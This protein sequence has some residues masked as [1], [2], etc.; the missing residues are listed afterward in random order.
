MKR[1]RFRTLHGRLT[2][3][4]VLVAAITICAL[5]VAFNLL[6]SQRSGADIDTRLRT[7]AAAAATTVGV[8]HGRLE[9]RESP[10]AAPLDRRVWIYAGRRAVERP[11][12]DATLQ[13]AADSMAGTAGRFKDVP[14]DGDVRLYSS[15]ITDAGRQ[16]GTVVAAQSLTA[17]ER[18]IQ[19]ALLGSTALAALLLGATL[20]VT[21]TSIGR[22]LGP[23]RAMTASA[24]EWSTNDPA[25]RFGTSDRPDELGQ[26]ARTFDGLLDRVAASL[27]HEQRLSAELSHELRTP[28]SRIVAEAELLQRQDR[29]PED[30]RRAHASI[31]RS[32]G[33]MSSILDTLMAASRA[34]A[35]LD[36]GRCD[37]RVALRE[38][39]RTWAPAFEDRGIELQIAATPGRLDAGVDAEVFQRIAAPLLDNARRY[40]TA[41]VV[42]EAARDNGAVVVSIVDDGPGV[43]EDE[44]ERVFEPGARLGVADGHRGAG[45]GLPLARRL[46]RAAN[47]DVSAMPAEPPPGARFR[48]ALPG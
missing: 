8:W 27:R 2:A 33:Q 4:A 48:V 14:A 18:T 44:R 37:V 46:A 26:M 35:G 42:V 9:A 29:A 10:G 43:P 39:S 47:G 22:A 21:R 36:R 19:L 7:H 45:L 34:E 20:V 15:P 25:R 38:L 31:L 11:P 1:P 32:A 40:A 23:V 3:V 12:G 13:R 30:R 17:Y 5:T 41:R 6:L 24:Q 28:L 16:I